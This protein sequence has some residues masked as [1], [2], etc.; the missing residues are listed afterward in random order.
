MGLLHDDCLVLCSRI[1]EN[2]ILRVCVCARNDVVLPNQTR[3]PCVSDHILLRRPPFFLPLS[4]IFVV[5]AA[6]LTRKMRSR[7]CF[8]IELA[9]C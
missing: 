6:W 8:V 7:E 2:S 4:L 1:Q 9:A 5:Q 3:P